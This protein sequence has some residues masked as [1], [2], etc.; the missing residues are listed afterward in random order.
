VSGEYYAATVSI[1]RVGIEITKHFSSYYGRCNK[2]LFIF[3]QRKVSGPMLKD[4]PLSAVNNGQF[5]PTLTSPYLDATSQFTYSGRTWFSQ[6]N[7]KTEISKKFI[8]HLSNHRIF[9]K[10]IVPQLVTYLSYI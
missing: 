4:Q 10:D 2:C 8:G 7:S 6:G 9:I 1:L 3:L 5:L